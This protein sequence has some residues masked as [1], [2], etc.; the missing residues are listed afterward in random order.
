MSKI[1]ISGTTVAFGPT[2]AA[3]FIPQPLAL[4]SKEEHFKTTKI[5]QVIFEQG[6]FNIV[7]NNERDIGDIG[8]LEEKITRIFSKAAMRLGADYA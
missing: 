3:Q 1:N 7:L 2:A 6:A 5:P 4:N 8:D